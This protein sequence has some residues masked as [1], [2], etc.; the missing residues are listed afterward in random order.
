[1]NFELN[2]RSLFPVEFMV[3]CSL[4]W[5]TKGVKYPHSYGRFFGDFVMG[6]Q[7]SKSWCLIDDIFVVLIVILFGEIK[8][9]TY[10]V[11]RGS[12]NIF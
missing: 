9:G 2:Q 12:I 1:M 10:L 5:D 8:N 4:R 3:R 11:W 7:T 6:E